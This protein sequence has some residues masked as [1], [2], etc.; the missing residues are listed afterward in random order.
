MVIVRPPPAAIFDV[1]VTD[2]QAIDFPYSFLATTLYAYFTPEG[3]VI[4]A[5]NLESVTTASFDSEIDGTEGALSEVAPS[6][7]ARVVLL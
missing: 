1:A 3:R 4:P 6:I 7:H 5:S 2:A